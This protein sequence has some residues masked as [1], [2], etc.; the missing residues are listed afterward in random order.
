MIIAPFPRTLW[1]NYIVLPDNLMKLLKK[2]LL[3]VL[4]PVL[5]LLVAG[6]NT[7]AQTYYDWLGTKSSDWTNPLNWQLNTSGTI[8]TPG[9][10]PGH[11]GF[12]D[13]AAVYLGVHV[14]IFGAVS[15]PVINTGKIINLGSL[16]LGDNLSTPSTTNYGVNRPI[17]LTINSTLNITGALTQEHS[18]AGN[19][20]SGYTL[21]GGTYY[22]HQAQN[23]IF[24]TGILNVVTVNIGDNHVPANNGVINVSQ[25]KF[26]N[27]TLVA[28]STLVVNVSGNMNIFSPA[29]KTGTV[30]NSVSDAEL[31]F[32]SGTLNM[33]GQVILTNVATPYTTPAGNAQFA[34]LDFFSVDLFNNSDSPVL[35]LYHATPF[36][37]SQ[38]GANQNNVDFYNIFSGPGTGTAT[39]NYAANGPQEVYV[40]NT[41]GIGVSIDN[42]GSNV[43]ADNHVYQNIIISGTGTKTVDPGFFDVA[44]NITLASGST[45]TLDLTTNNPTPTVGGYF[46]SYLGTSFKNGNKALT[47]PGT[48][49]NGGNFNNA[50]GSN[51]TL[52]GAFTNSGTFN[53][54][55]GGTITVSNTT[56]NSGTYN[57]SGTA[58]A[59]FTGA[60]S[61]TGTINQSNSGGMTF[62]AAFT[63]SGAGSIL[64]QTSSGP[65]VFSN[66]MTNQGTFTQSAGLI[67]IAG[68]VNNSGTLNL[69]SANFTMADNFTNSGNFIAGA[70]T[71][72]FNATK[73]VQLNDSSPGGTTFNNVNFTSGNNAVMQSGT[74]AVSS[75][76]IMTL[77]TSGTKVTADA[78]GS[79]LIF[80]SDANGSATL[81]ALPSGCQVNGSNVTVQ[82]F[83]AGGF[84]NG[85]T[86]RG[87]RLVSPSV[88]TATNPTSLNNIYSLSYLL[89]STYISGTAFPTGPTTKTGN[90]SLYLYRENL[91]PA[92]TTFLNSNYR[93]I[94]SYAS[95]PYYVINTDSDPGNTPLYDI[96]VGNAYLFFFRGGITTSTPFSTSSVPDDGT[97]AAT[98]TLNQG[99]ISVTNWYNE[100]QG[101]TGMLV[102]TASGDPGIEGMNL[103]GNPYPSTID[104]NTF[105]NST[106]SAPI[107]GPGLS[108]TIYLLNPG[109]QAGAGNYGSYIPGIGGTN[110]ATNLIASGV[111]FFVQAVTPN[112][113]LTFTESAK[114][115]TQV[116]GSAL[117]MANKQSVTAA[118]VKQQIRLLMQ[119][120]SVNNDETLISF[121]ANTKSAF[122]T[123]EDAHYRTG[124]GKVS[125]ASMSSDNVPLAINQLPLATKGDT[126]KLKVGAAASGTYTLKLESATGIP[127]IYD[128]WLKDAFTK[129]SVDLRKTS[130]YSFTV[131]TTDTTTSGANRFKLVL[132]QDPALAYQLLSFDAEKT[133]N[134]RQGQ[135]TWKTKNEEDYTRFAV[136]R[137]SDNG[138]NYTIIGSMTS[139]GQGAY[140]LVDQKPEKGVNIYRLKQTDFNN[141]IT[142]SNIVDLHFGENSGN[143]RITCFP[144][145]AINNIC[146]GFDPK[147]NRKT[148]YDIRVTNSTGKV[149]RFA[150]ITDTTWRDNVSNLLTG[151]YLIQVTDKKDNSIIGQTKFVK[152]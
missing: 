81:A 75:T 79:N 44:G 139:N 86:T 144:N 14:A 135:L 35:N 84:V 10:Y 115:S 134:G 110:N 56:T 45:A 138:K 34:P 55:G 109:G 87:Y 54:S 148:T 11:V 7:Y 77:S 25:L 116:S 124:S 32:A 105:S 145:P 8:T 37:I 120:D 31:S 68:A 41:T 17:T 95:D 36:V 104:W 136:E 131:T 42:S 51:V 29:S 82:R 53:Q 85:F 66:S 65:I 103:V 112:S 89:N 97:L 76:G 74:F 122:N 70:G 90:P 117:F 13:G 92:F 28:G 94:E 2:Y 100:Q 119:M 141:N 107:Y 98:G 62:S 19:T 33:T 128:I 147:S 73:T 46:F 60:V 126:I 21:T 151:T 150:Q 130:T 123:M 113:P 18:T 99:P 59:T 125:L 38:A 93:G 1:F 20:N 80:K 61:N 43:I 129:D 15:K 118:A 96:P 78:G 142:Y 91:V 16:D 24:G 30:I 48:T 146:V 111:G 57:Q 83:V 67:T 49:T 22:Y 4:L 152:L 71:A 64:N 106:S 12:T 23:Y 132:Q 114:I 137:S 101:N 72:I 102:T 5:F 3:A 149:V 47:I 6:E 133:G 88:W 121:G 9:D 26:G 143:T 69:G 127:Q 63:N 50:N 40:Y 39:V 52:T 108:G 27:N 58:L 140:S